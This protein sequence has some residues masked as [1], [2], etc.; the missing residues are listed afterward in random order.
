MKRKIEEYL[1]EVKDFRAEKLEQLESFRIEFLSK[2]GK[3]PSLY[4]DFRHIDPADRKEVGQLINKL[5]NAVYDK[6]VTL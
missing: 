1:I 6:I 3:I 4:N 5:K 2:K